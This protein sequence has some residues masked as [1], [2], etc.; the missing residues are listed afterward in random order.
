MVTRTQVLQTI[1]CILLATYSFGAACV[2][3]RP[4]FATFGETVLVSS[5]VVLVLSWIAYFVTKHTQH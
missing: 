5:V 1:G 4:R 2:E 3:L